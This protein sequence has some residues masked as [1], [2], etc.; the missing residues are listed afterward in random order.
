MRTSIVM[1]AALLLAA[2]AQPV[3]P[4][5]VALVGEWQS[6]DMYLLLLPEGRVKYVRREGNKQTR[7]DGPL[8]GFDGDRFTVGVWFMS[9]TFSVDK[10]PYE[11]G[12]M[13]RMVVDGVELT[14][15]GDGSEPTPPNET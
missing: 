8:R 9:T 10:A 14:R 1:L 7:I 5:K 15:I 6:P 13:L 4:D 11:A 2:C 12:G 3:P